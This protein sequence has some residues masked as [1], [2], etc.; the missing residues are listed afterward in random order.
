MDKMVS[1]DAH[2]VPV[3]GEDHHFAAGV[4]EFQP[5]SEG[6]GPSVENVEDVGLKIG[7]KPPGTPDPPDES[8]VFEDTQVI[9]RPEENIQNRPVP[10]AG[11]EDQRKGP[12]PKVPVSQ[13]MHCKTFSPQRRSQSKKRKRQ[14]MNHRDR[15]GRRE[16]LW[17][18]KGKYPALKTF[19]G[20]SLAYF[21][22]AVSATSVVKLLFLKFPQECELPLPI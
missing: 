7:G 18:N 16:F 13:G 19:W 22:S 15:R 20:L 3:S 8:Q 11:A 4:G 1:P 9:H 2:A 17:K 6:N 21:S 12:F 5:A 14:M 10:A